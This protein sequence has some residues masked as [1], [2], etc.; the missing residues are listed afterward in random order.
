MDLIFLEMVEVFE[1]ALSRQK[2]RFDRAVKDIHVRPREFGVKES[3]TSEYT[4]PKA[5]DWATYWDKAYSKLTN[6][7]LAS[8]ER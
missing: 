5:D 2:P 8:M 1:A 7:R 3:S 6:Y 4:R